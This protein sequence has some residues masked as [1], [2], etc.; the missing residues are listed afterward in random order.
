[1]ENEMSRSEIVALVTALVLGCCLAGC[2]VYYDDDDDDAAGSGSCFYLCEGAYGDVSACDTSADA[3]GSEEACED[4]AREDC[5]DMPWR[6]AEWVED[7]DGC[8]EAC[9]PDFY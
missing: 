8:D 4:W 2:P 3:T 5:G 6:V 7:C 9:A 1:M